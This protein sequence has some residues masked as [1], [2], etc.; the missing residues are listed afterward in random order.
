MEAFLL[1]APTPI[2]SRQHDHGTQLTYATKVLHE[3]H[4]HLRE[5]TATYYATR[6]GCEQHSDSDEEEVDPI[7][8]H[9]HVFTDGSCHLEH[10]IL[11]AG[12][13]VIGKDENGRQR[14]KKVQFRVPHDVSVNTTDTASLARNPKQC[15]STQAE[16]AAIAFV[17]QR[18]RGLVPD[19][20]NLVFAT[21]SMACVR[22]LA[23]EV[24]RQSILRHI[25]TADR[26]YI[27][28]IRS[29]PGFPLIRVVH[30][31]AHNGDKY[32]TIAD[33]LAATGGFIPDARPPQRFPHPSTPVK[34]HLF[35]NEH[36]VEGDPRAHIRA[37][38]QEIHQR[39]WERKE[40]HGLLPRLARERGIKLT[41][42]TALFGGRML[43]TYYA[44][45]ISNTL[46]TPA[47]RYKLKLLDSPACP[48]CPDTPKADLIHV[49]YGCQH[50]EMAAKRQALTLAMLEILTT[51]PGTPS[52]PRREPYMESH[53]LT[54]H[55][56]NTIAAELMYPLSPHLWN[57]PAP[58]RL[59]LYGLP[60]AR[61]YTQTGHTVTVRPPFHDFRYTD[62]TQ[63]SP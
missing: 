27:H 15:T 2:D 7:H 4:T 39:Q 19:F 34:F 59:F 53:S 54:P 14:A 18:I 30:V 21:D 20:D 35:Y 13:V 41:R 49:L 25:R 58:I 9:S 48:L 10:G 63:P 22:T 6:F 32:N 46:L 44:R 16:L 28:T 38:Q 40:S 3:L 24:P 61:L 50:P 11:G 60:E 31:K 55:P 52:K 26:D 47:H 36:R 12:V 45:L 57:M 43:E 23:P 42:A 5:Q 56:A 51:T 29:H 37:V 33:R 1:Y 8:A 17:M 62:E